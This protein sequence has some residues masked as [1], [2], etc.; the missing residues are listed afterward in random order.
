MFVSFLGERMSFN[1]ELAL[2]KGILVGLVVIPL[3]ACT[4]GGGGGVVAVSSYEDLGK[5]SS[6]MEGT[7]RLVS[8]ENQQYRCVDGY[9]EKYTFSIGQKKDKAENGRVEI[10]SNCPEKA[11]YC[12]NSFEE[13]A[14]MANCNAQTE[15]VEA[16]A[17]E[18]AYSTMYM[19]D[20]EELVEP[21]IQY[22]VYTCMPDDKTR[23]TW[24]WIRDVCEYNGQKY[25]PGEG[26]LIYNECFVT[27]LRCINGV[28]QGMG[29]GTLPCSAS[30]R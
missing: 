12:F 9:W 25:R 8:D 15:G 3:A 4:G 2:F 21:Y 20:G 6:A 27:D 22:V 1:K 10:V 23:V 16:Y 17:G 30:S 11:T 5:C 13:L 24:S 7:I 18:M 19:A 28:M 14:M 29:G 26:L